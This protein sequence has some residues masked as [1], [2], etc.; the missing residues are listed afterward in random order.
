MK[1]T[2]E[3]L[4]AKKQRQQKIVALTCYDYPTAILEEQAGIDVI[5]VGDSVG[6]NILGYDNETQV[7]MDDIVHHLKAVRRGAPQSYILA[8]LPYASY[9]TPDQALDNAQR[10]VSAGADIVKFEGV[11]PDLATYLI[12]HD[13]E[14][15]G[16]IGLQPQT[17]QQK[18]V[19]GKNFVQA[20]ELLEGALDLEASGI[21]LLVLELVPEE[22]GKLITERLQIPTIGIGA[23]RFTDGQVLIVNDILGITPRKLRLAKRYQDYQNTTLRTIHRYADD[24]VQQMFP[25]EENVRHM[26]IEELQELTEWVRVN[27]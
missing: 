10:L 14:V 1:K 22:V 11:Q 12:K 27:L 7:T 4:I 19:Q 2:S 15:C 5:F 3:Q 16:H 8:D 6:T 23:G 26:A 9:E 20:K 13:I 18:A 21:K 25:A 24:V 17:H